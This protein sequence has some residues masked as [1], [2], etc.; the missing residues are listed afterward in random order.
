[1]NKECV[2]KLDG[3]IFS[4]DFYKLIRTCHCYSRIEFFLS[5]K[6]QK[7]IRALR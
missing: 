3:P 2:R 7:M 1:M 4:K 6:F 5:L